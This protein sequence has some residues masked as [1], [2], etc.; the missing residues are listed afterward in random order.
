VAR[1]RQADRAAQPRHGRSRRGHGDEA[2]DR[3]KAVETEGAAGYCLQRIGDNDRL[4]GVGDG[5]HEGAARAVAVQDIGDESGRE[6]GGA[7]EGA[8]LAADRH[9]DAAG[10]AGRGPEY[11]NVF[12]LGHQTEAE[13]SG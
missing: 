1:E 6:N 5:E 2:P 9:E 8:L 12:R 11:R 4:G 3:P 7:H 10:D 13:P